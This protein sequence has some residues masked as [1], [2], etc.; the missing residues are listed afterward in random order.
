MREIHAAQ[1]A[2]AVEALCLE[3]NRHL[4]KDVQAALQAARAREESPLGRDVLEDLL[5][6]AAL[7]AKT[8]LPLCQ[9]TGLAVLFVD[10]GQDVH[11]CGGD[12]NAA[13][14]EGVRRGYTKGYLRMSTVDDPLGARTKREDNGPPVVH[15]RLVSGDRLSITLAPKGAG[16]ENMSALAM[17]KPADGVEGVKRFVL[18]AVARAGGNFCP[19]GVVG[20]GVGG[21]AEMASIL[22]KRALLRPLGSPGADPAAAAL[23][24]ALLE[25]INALGIGP[26]G[27]GGTIT[28]L[29]VHVETFPCHMASLPVALNLQCHA[30]RHARVLL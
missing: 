22:A 19:P 11:I 28:A 5:E 15:L 12:F 24:A 14:A 23:E 6:N 21:T 1:I 2:D 17:L 26:Q 4:P 27:F 16:S 7:A 25:G 10:M 20:V 3:A 13:L 29:A 30:A 8:G 9:D 18:D